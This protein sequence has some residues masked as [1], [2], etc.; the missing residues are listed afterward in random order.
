MH[1]LAIIFMVFTI[2]WVYAKTTVI[3][4]PI[5]QEIGVMVTWQADDTERECFP[6]DGRVPWLEKTVMLSHDG[7]TPG[8]PSS[9]VP[10]TPPYTCVWSIFGRGK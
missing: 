5:G 7:S 1:R 3:I 4:D 6:H 10:Y 2:S 9:G 8:A